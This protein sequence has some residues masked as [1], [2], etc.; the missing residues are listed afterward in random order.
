MPK[1]LCP[2]RHPN[3]FLFLEIQTR[4]CIGLQGLRTQNHTPLSWCAHWFHCTCC[5]LKERRSLVDS[6]GYVATLYIIPHSTLNT[7]P[8]PVRPWNNKK[9][10]YFLIMGTNLLP[11]I[12]FTCLVP[13]STP[14]FI[15]SKFT[16]VDKLGLR[17]K[18]RTW[19]LS[20]RPYTLNV[21]LWMYHSTTGVPI[22]LGTPT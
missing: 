21:T 13:C 11:L 1:P 9:S 19:Y 6:Y 2:A 12:V 17:S 5:Q 18:D 22:P 3:R 10:P 16:C 14:P 15:F 7:H 8:H 20:A 4:F